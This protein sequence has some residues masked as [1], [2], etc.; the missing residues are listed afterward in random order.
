MTEVPDELGMGN[1]NYLRPKITMGYSNG[2]DNGHLKNIS[3][4]FH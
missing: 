2:M 4:M 1:C 3:M